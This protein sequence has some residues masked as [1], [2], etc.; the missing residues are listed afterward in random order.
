MF[1]RKRHMGIYSIDEIAA[2]VGPIADEYGAEGSGCSV[3]TPVEKLIAA[4][5]SI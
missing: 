2:I 5:T 4:T 1:H 3:H